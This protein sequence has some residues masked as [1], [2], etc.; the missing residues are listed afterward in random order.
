MAQPSCSQPRWTDIV[1]RQQQFYD[2]WFDATRAAKTAPPPEEGLAGRL[3]G[4]LRQQLHLF[5]RRIGV[6]SYV[7][8]LHRRWLGDLSG[9]RV[10]D[11][12]CF[13]GTYL[14]L[15]IAA[16]CGEYIG[17]DLS[18]RAVADLSAR[19]QAHNLPHARAVA[20]DFLTAGFP[21][22][23]FDVIYASGVLHHFADL[24]AALREVQRVLKPG[25]KVIAHDPMMTEPLNRLARLAYR[26]LQRDRDWEFPFTRRSLEQIQQYFAI[27]DMRGVF[28]MARLSWPM[29]LVPGFERVARRL[30]QWG[31]RIDDRHT[32]RPGPPFCQ[33]WQATFLLRKRV[34]A[35]TV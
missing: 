18:E 9:Q 32:R 4:A 2:G 22:A 16:R 3:W 14:T 33:C 34:D 8:S 11:L 17:I 13:Q 1:A 31:L 15:E 7:C 6:D 5:R 27:D 23:C 19:F 29:F 30:A 35:G 28:G 12:G 24:D 26:P 20:G 10:L 25:G 21:S